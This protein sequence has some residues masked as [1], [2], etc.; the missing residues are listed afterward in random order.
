MNASSH[1]H[2]SAIEFEIA[3]KLIAD[4]TGAG[5]TICVYEGG[6][7]A[8]RYATDHAAILEALASTS[9]DELLIYEKRD[10]QG[11]RNR[12][13]WI[14]LVWGNDSDL[15]SDF[16]ENVEHLVAGASTIAENYDRY[17]NGFA[18]NTTAR[19][20]VNLDG[21]NTVLVKLRKG[22]EV[23]HVEGG[24]TDE[25]YSYTGRTWRFDGNFVTVSYAT[26]A[27]DCDGRIHRSGSSSCT[28][29]DLQEGYRSPD[30]ER[31]PFARNGVILPIIFPKWRETSAS[32]RDYAAEAAGY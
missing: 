24:Q 18:P 27:V 25:G 3:K 7:F 32:Q 10:A 31:Y 11:N 1:P 22:Q 20:W 29:A 2:M 21:G 30:D 4:I 5:Y 9:D 8:L 26:N 12:V 14:H 19:F 28:L 17:G 23:S 6:D 16:T 13:G 15:I